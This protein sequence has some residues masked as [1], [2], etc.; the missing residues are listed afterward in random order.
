MGLLRLYLALCVIFTHDGVRQNSIPLI[1]YNGSQA[2][3]IFFVI[4]GFYMALILSEKYRSPVEFYASRFIRI[5]LPYWTVLGIVV[6]FSL[7]CGM[8]FGEWG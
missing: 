8:V 4:S 3:Q 7:F 6:I 1:I 5:Y 2:V